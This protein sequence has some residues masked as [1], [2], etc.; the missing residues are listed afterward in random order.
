ME[1]SFLPTEWKPQDSVGKRSQAEMPFLAQV[2]EMQLM[3]LNYI[4]RAPFSGCLINAVLHSGLEDQ[5]VAEAI[6]ISAGYMSKFLRGVGEQW[7]KRLVKFMRVTQSLAPLQWLAHQMGCDIVVRHSA[8]AELAA[9]R[10]RV[11]ELE[12]QYGRSAA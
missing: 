1:R 4:D 5:H 7:A 12:R 9:A 8:A 10:S 2:G 3:S 11:M 6:P